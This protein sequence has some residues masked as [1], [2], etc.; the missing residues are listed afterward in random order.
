MTQ[1]GWLTAAFLGET[2]GLEGKAMFECVES[3]CA[4]N[5]CLRQVSVEAHRLW[6]KM[7]MQLQAIVEEEWERKRMGI[8]LDFGGEGT[9]QICSFMWADNFRIMSHS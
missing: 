9:H 6:Q 5:R 7:A 1:N 4:F 8:L 2:A 3:S